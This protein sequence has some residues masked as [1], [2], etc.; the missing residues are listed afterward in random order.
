MTRRLL[1]SLGTATFAFI[2]SSCAAAPTAGPDGP[3][4]IQLTTALGP[5]VPGQTR[6]LTA[7][8]LDDNGAPIPDAVITFSTNLALVATVSASGEVT[9]HTAG[10]ARITAT[11]GSTTNFR[12][13]T[14]VPGGIAL[15]TGGTL[16][17]PGVELVI[18]AG[19]VA[20]PTVIMF[21][22]SANPLLDPT[23]SVGS[24]I[25]V[26]PGDVAFVVPATLRRTF[27]PAL[28][29]VGWPLA[30]LRLRRFD[31]AAWVGIAGGSADAD[32]LVAS[33]PIAGAG[34]YS[35]GW[36]RPDTACT[37]AESRQFDFWI[38]AWSV[39]EG[40]VVHGIS[41]ITL[42]PGGCA[43]MERYQSAGVGRS[44]SFWE[45]GTGKWYQT[46]IDDVGSRLLLAG[47]F[48]GGHLDMLNPVAGGTVHW[49]TRWSVEGANVRQQVQAFTNN[50][51]ATYA[52]PTYNLL[53][54]PR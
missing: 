22:A 39:A 15:P 34:L 3:A 6:Q 24:T 27:N 12:D 44:I 17:G 9:A 25:A 41:D 4:S 36:A 18:P 13:F 47:T 20:A 28:S 38:G 37:A 31:G 8:A 33:A 52:A 23:E 7:T 2:I 16:S 49:R 29:P 21:Q 45:P 14:V 35:V 42:E 53:Y 30:N 54:T 51:G 48:A 10:T 5:L 46:Y 32:Q 1:L 26:A 50:G 11:S 43:I 19:A 40:A